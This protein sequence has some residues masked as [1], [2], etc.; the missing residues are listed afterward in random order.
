[1][2]LGIT[3][4]WCQ[5]D[6][7][8]DTR[9]HSPRLVRM[10]QIRSTRASGRRSRRVTAS[11]AN[12]SRI[13]SSRRRQRAGAAKDAAREGEEGGCLGPGLRRL[14][15]TTGGNVDDGAERDRH[16]EKGKQRKK[17]LSLSDS[18]RSHWWCEEV[19]QEGESADGCQHCW[20]QTSDERDSDH[21]QQ[22][23]QDVGGQGDVRIDCE[24]QHSQY[25]QS[26]DAQDETC[27]AAAKAEPPRPRRHGLS[28]PLPIRQRCAVASW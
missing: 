4:A 13:C 8:T 5:A 20:E 15:S 9:N 19:V 22:E 12:V 1:M 23:R 28:F 25:R 7:A 18:E 17:V 10:L 16:D 24:Q 6:W 26:G 3:V 21:Q 27:R 14:A 11:K 2:H